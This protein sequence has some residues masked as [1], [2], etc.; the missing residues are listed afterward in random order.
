MVVVQRSHSM[1]HISHF[2][3]HQTARALRGADWLC[4]VWMEDTFVYSF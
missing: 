2:I 3:K 1:S 4:G